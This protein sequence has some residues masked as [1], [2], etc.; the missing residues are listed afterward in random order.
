MRG[1][2]ITIMMDKSAVQFIAPWIRRVRAVLLL[3][4][5]L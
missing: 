5:A 3:E 2:D 1:C 4:A